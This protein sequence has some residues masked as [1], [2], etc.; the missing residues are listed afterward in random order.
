[1]SRAKVSDAATAAAAQDKQFRRASISAGI[2]TSIVPQLSTLQS[3]PS[4][5]KDML[6]FI[7][8]AKNIKHMSREYI[9][10]NL[11][12]E[13]TDYPGFLEALMVEIKPLLK[14]ARWGATLRILFVLVMTYADMITDVL[15]SAEYYRTGNFE[16]FNTSWRAMII[17]V[18]SRTKT[19]LTTRCLFSS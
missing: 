10:L 15:V 19:I 11:A 9:D 2:E 8:G 18:G 4:K 17:G 6:L 13:T 1:M 12:A 5:V 7:Q 14:F 3:N 16:A